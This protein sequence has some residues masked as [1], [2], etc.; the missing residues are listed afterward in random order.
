MVLEW[1][2]AVGILISWPLVG[3][4]AIWAFRKPLLALQGCLVLRQNVVRPASD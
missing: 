3:L 2:K 1:V 4:I